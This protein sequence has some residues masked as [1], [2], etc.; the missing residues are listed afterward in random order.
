[1]ARNGS[2]WLAMA[3]L[4]EKILI[5]TFTIHIAHT[6]TSTHPSTC[7]VRLS[8]Y[9]FIRSSVHPIIRLSVHPCPVRYSKV[10][11]PIVFPKNLELYRSPRLVEIL[12][13]IRECTTWRKNPKIFKNPFRHTIKKRCEGTLII[14][15]FLIEEQSINAV[16]P[17]VK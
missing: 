8:V 14:S 2:Q 1:M 3:R 13:V 15:R 12:A 7:H 6:I 16:S 9:P 17:S 5:R 10:I 11:R 4:N